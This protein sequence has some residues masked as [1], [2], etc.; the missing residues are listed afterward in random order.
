MKMI[1]WNLLEVPDQVISQTERQ[2]RG[3]HVDQK[4]EKLLGNLP[5]PRPEFP[6]VFL[7]LKHVKP[8]LL[9]NRQLMN[10]CLLFRSIRTMPSNDEEH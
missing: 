4:K 10:L 6:P 7:Y 2:R 1:Q 9:C 5:R 8:A 3:L